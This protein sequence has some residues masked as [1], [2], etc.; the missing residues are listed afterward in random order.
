M[1]RTG[2]I[3]DGAWPRATLSIV[4]LETVVILVLESLVLREHVLTITQAGN[5]NALSTPNVIYPIL[6]ILGIV[7]LFTLC[8]DAMYH[9]NQIQVVAFTFFNFLCFTYG[10]IQT[11]YDWKALG[12]STVLKAYDIAIAVTMGVCSIFLTFAAWKLAAVFGW[13]MY[14]FLG[15]DVDMRRMHKGYEILITILKFD[16]FFFVAFAIQLF[17]LVD[18]TDKVIFATFSDGRTFSRH[19]LFI[20]LSIPA[21]VILLILSFY[22]VMKENKIATLFVLVCLVATEPYFIYQMVYIHLPDN[23]PRF[24]NSAKYLTFFI[25]VTMV[26]VLMTVFC[27]IYCFRNFG[28]GLLISKKDKIMGPKR[29]FEIDEDPE[30]TV[31]A[32]PMESSRYGEDGAGQRLMAAAPALKQIQEKYKGQE[33]KGN[34]HKGGFSEK[35]T[36]ALASSTRPLHSG[37]ALGS[38]GSS[39]LSQASERTYHD[40]MELE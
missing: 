11:L 39:P 2:L 12:V 23:A 17:T 27:M 36:P 22:G 37:G 21:A 10:I 25:A 19:Q 9:R 24:T 35:H 20:G 14:R 13:E 33:Q 26:L 30:E 8:V 32:I 40:K 6:Y 7:C 3:V 18:S 29:P 5:G 28:K 16:V 31:P 38:A 1:S 34:H 4:T 15:A